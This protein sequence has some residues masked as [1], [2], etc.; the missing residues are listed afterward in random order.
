MSQTFEKLSEL[1]DSKPTFSEVTSEYVVY[2]TPWATNELSVSRVGGPLYF[3]GVSPASTSLTFNFSYDTE[4]TTGYVLN[5][6]Y[7]TTEQMGSKATYNNPSTSYTISGLSSNTNYFWKTTL[8][9]S[10]NKFYSLLGS[11]KTNN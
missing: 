2:T 6:E 8:I 4:S 3:V 11:Q 1:Y 7:G 9:D 10:E 5:I